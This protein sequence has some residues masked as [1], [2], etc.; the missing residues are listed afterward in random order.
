M[1]AGLSVGVRTRRFGYGT[2]A[3]GNTCR[4]LKDIQAG[5][6]L[7]RF[8]PMAPRLLARV[9]TR[10]FG[11]G[12]PARG[13]TC[14]LLKDIREGS[15]LR[16]FHPMAPRLLVRVTT[17]QFGCGILALENGCRPLLGI[18]PLASI[19]VAFSPDGTTLASASYYEYN[20]VVGRTHRRTP[21]DAFWG[22][23]V[24]GHLS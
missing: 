22:I 2:S 8:R 20:S 9:T 14:S 11:C 24:D 23:R 13:N 16:L 3:Q 7:W 18:R 21:A 12:T 1:E 6:I 5:L 19:S 10:R 15:I 17:I 4:L